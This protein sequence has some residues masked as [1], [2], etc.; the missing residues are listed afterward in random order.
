DKDKDHESK[1]PSIANTNLITHPYEDEIYEDLDQ[2]ELEVLH[3]EN[4]TI[5]RGLAPLEEFFN[6]NDVVK[7]PKM[8]STKAD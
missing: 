6:F 8:E 3:C 4:D 7:K 1:L 2:R 5:P